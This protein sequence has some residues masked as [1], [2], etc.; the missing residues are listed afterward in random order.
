MWHM[1]ASGGIALGY[2]LARDTIGRL[3]VLGDEL[4]AHLFELIVVVEEEVAE[5]GS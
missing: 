2:F 1:S 3:G 5:R 4:V